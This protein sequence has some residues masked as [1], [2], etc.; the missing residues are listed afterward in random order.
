MTRTALITGAS[1]GIGRAIALG[2]ATDGIALIGL[3]YH[4]NTAAAA[5]TAKGLKAMGADVIPL[6]ADLSTDAASAAPRLASE[7]LDA[8]EERT[9]ARRLD[10]LV[11]NV[12]GAQPRAFETVDEATYRRELDLNLTAPLFLLQTLIP[13][14]GAGGRVVNVSTGFTKVAAPDHLV[15]GAAKSALNYLTLC[16]APLLGQRGATI[17]AVIPGVIETDRNAHWLAISARREAANALS[18]FNRVG[19]ADD[20]AALVR[21]LASP[22]A[23]WT[24][25]Q[26]IDVSGGS[27]L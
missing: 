14:I 2:L 8:V 10:V 17:N 21:F 25:G 7:F 26:C 27:R 1:R 12:G 6:T 9:G 18:V 4:D 3:H 16:L 13:Y 5:Q 24:T 15:Y 23:G 11:N 19:T 22:A 20:V